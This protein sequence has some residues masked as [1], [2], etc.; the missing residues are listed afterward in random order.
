MMIKTTITIPVS[1]CILL[2]GGAIPTTCHF[3]MTVCVIILCANQ[4]LDLM[5]QYRDF[6]DFS[7]FCAYIC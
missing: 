2:V 5:K 7:D 4:K 1:M 6:C 3:L